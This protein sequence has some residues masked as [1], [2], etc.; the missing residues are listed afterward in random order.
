MQQS[1]TALSLKEAKSILSSVPP[2]EVNAGNTEP[3]HTS[4][5]IADGGILNQGDVT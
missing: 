1:I 3:L 5:G 4:H 2:E